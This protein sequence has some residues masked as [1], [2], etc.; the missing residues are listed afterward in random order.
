VPRRRG[1]LKKP[2]V[3]LSAAAALLV[4]A[5]VTTSVSFSWRPASPDAAPEN[6]P[7]NGAPDL[8]IA[9]AKR[10][11]P[12][13]IDYRRLDERL[14]RLAQEPSMVG[15]AVGIV[16]NGEIRF[17]KGYGITYGGGNEPVTADTIFRWASVSKGVAADMVAKLAGDGRLS[18]YEPVAKYA[19]SL[20]LP[21]GNEHRATVSDVLSHRL[22]LFSHANDSKLEDGMNPRYLRSELATLNSICPPGSCWAYQNVAYDAAS[23]IVEKVTGKPYQQA[24]REQLFLPLGM[25]SATMSR[26]GLVTARSW[27]R[28]HRGGKNSKPVEVTEPYYRVPAAGGVNSSIKDLAIWM[29]AQ[30]GEAPEVLSPKVLS[31]VQSPRASTPGELG[32]MRKFRERL[33]TAAY[34]LGWRIYDYAGHRIIGHRG[35]VT[36]YRSLVMF[37]PES[38]SGVVALWNSSATQPGGLEFEVMDMI[39]RLPFKDWMELDGKKGPP[40]PQPQEMLKEEEEEEAPA[41]PPPAAAKAKAAEAQPRS[42]NGRKP[43]AR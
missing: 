24:V 40:L 18:L 3:I 26:D 15:L 23:E 5:W 37:D 43:S 28:P 21:A 1:S 11:A 32:R 27:A 9:E 36:G 17:V 41:S 4:A 33:N 16:E 29:Q 7:G 39:F 8:T 42:A 12:A 19:V 22:G 31:A 10:R 13:R 30:M 25:S 38:K 2:V 35:G 34:G 14:Q 20:R 6:L